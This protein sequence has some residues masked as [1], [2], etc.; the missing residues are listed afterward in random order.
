MLK[1]LENDVGKRVAETQVS[2][3]GMC[4]GDVDVNEY[5]S[6]KSM[7]KESDEGSLSNDSS[8]MHYSSGGKY[9]SAEESNSLKA[10]TRL[11]GSL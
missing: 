5:N 7:L 4:E 1:S 6:R 9:S 10:D 3:C 11:W 8:T 2:E